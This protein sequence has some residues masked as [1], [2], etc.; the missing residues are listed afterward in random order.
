MRPVDDLL[1]P[2][3]A[4]VDDDPDAITL[5]LAHGLEVDP[6]IADRF[7]AGAHREMDEPA[8]PAG[9]LGVHDGRGVEVEDFS[10]DPD[11]DGRTR[12]SS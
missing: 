9:H 8:H 10:G 2:A 7:L 3:A 12:R 1:D 5:V 6:G 11:L 4:G